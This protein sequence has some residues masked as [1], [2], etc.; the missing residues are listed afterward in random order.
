MRQFDPFGFEGRRSV[1]PVPRVFARPLALPS[2]FPAASASSGS[3]VGSQQRSRPRFTSSRRSSPSL[4]EEAEHEGFRSE[5][6]AVQAPL[7]RPL[8]T[9]SCFLRADEVPVQSPCRSA[10]RVPRGPVCSVRRSP[11]LPDRQAGS[12]CLR[13][14]QARELR[15][16]LLAALA[17][18][19]SSSGSWSAKYRKGERLANSC[20]WKSRGVLGASSSSAGHCPHRGRD[21][22]A[23]GCGHPAAGVGDLVMV[24]D[25]D[26]EASP[27]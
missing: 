26:D 24:L 13:H 7:R 2:T 1:S 17:H 19:R 8:N 20:P 16:E 15:Q 3:G 9:G 25:E 27:A 18:E 14:C 12:A 10:Y 6:R 22:S 4:S 5:H 21:R 11:G 23:D